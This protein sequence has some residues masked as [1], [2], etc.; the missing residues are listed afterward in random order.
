MNDLHIKRLI[1]CNEADLLPE[2]GEIKAS[3]L[4]QYGINL[5]QSSL[6]K[7]SPFI[8]D[9]PFWHEFIALYQE[10][11]LDHK[12]PQVVAEFIQAYSERIAT[13]FARVSYKDINEPRFSAWQKRQYARTHFELGIRTNFK[14]TS[15]LPFGFELS[16]GCTVGCWFCAASSLPFEGNFVYTHNNSRLWKE[17]L[18]FMKNLVDDPFSQRYICYYGTDPFDNPDYEK[19]LLDW[20]DIFKSFP[21]TTT[22]K[23]LENPDRTKKFLDLAKQHNGWFNRFS[24]LSENKFKKILKLFSPEELAFVF[25]VVQ[26]GP[27][28]IKSFSGRAKHRFLNKT[29]PSSLKF[30]PEEASSCACI[31]GFLINMVDKKIT[32]MSPS[33]T[34]DDW[35]EGQIVFNES[36]FSDDISFKKTIQDIIQNRMH[37][38]IKELPYVRTNPNLQ[39][40]FTPKGFSIRSK[41]M[42]LNCDTLVC[43]PE[44]GLL[45]NQGNLTA[46]QIAEKQWDRFGINPLQTYH[47]LE[48]IFQQGALDEGLTPK[49]ATSTQFATTC[50]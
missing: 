48:T 7:I 4:N 45:I 33:A 46:K 36:Y 38:S 43:A 35:P 19:F 31:S 13:N 30:L 5:S 12:Y 29:P 40:V 23:A 10:K 24:V 3:D 37:I 42:T 26:F 27:K 9:F 17:I 50:R 49:G 34:S 2:S 14:Y 21:Q 15:S 6:D 32:L 41:W 47:D 20:F 1:E 44:L 16:K 18:I 8:N 11:T 25:L 28:S 22:A 39:L